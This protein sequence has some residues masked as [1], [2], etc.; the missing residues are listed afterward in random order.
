MAN[1]TVDELTFQDPNALPDVGPKLSCSA[2]GQLSLKVGNLRLDDGREIF[3]N[4]NGQ[5]RCGDNHRRIF[6]NNSPR[7]MEVYQEGDIIFFTG[8]ADTEQMRILG[9]GESK[10]GIGTA[11]PQA[12][13]QVAGG[14]IMPAVGDSS[15]AGIQFPAGATGDEAFIRYFPVVGETAK[16]QIGIGNDLDDSLSLVQAGAE[17]LTITNGRVGI[18]TTTPS[19]A[20]H[21]EPN[22]IQSG[23]IG[24]GLSFGNRQTT[25]FVE[26]PTGGERWIWYASGGVARL[27]SGS[28]KLAVTSTG[29]VGIGTSN[30]Q[31]RLQIL[32][33]AI[34]PAVG[35]S[36]QAGIQ[37]PPDPGGGLGDEAYIRYFVT[38]GE[39]TRLVIGV[40]NDADDAI[41]LFQAGGERLT[42]F[43]G[44]VGIGNLSPTARL[45]VNGKIHAGNSDLYFTKVDHTHTGFGNITGFAAIENASDYNALMILGRSGTPQGRLVRLWDYLDVNGSLNITGSVGIGTALGS[46]NPY[47][48]FEINRGWGDWISLRASQ[49]NGLWHLHNPQGGD[50]FEIGRNE[51]WGMFVIKNAGN[52][53]IGT[54]EPTAKFHVIGNATK[55]V[56][57]TGWTFP[58]D[59]RLKRNIEPLTGTLERLLQLRGV[60]FEWIEP[61]KMG[62]PHALQ[63]GL[64]A[65]EVETVFPEWVSADAQGC[66]HL[67]MTGFEALLIEALRELK[68]EIDFLKWKTG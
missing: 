8:N 7:Q 33:G 46:V 51:T 5:L 67:T 35:N 11:A 20:L 41:G 61:E 14:A 21:V 3:F 55:T 54:V 68:S 57:G 13:L 42:V 6:F 48:N 32:G 12:K 53:G 17:R 10:V 45:D 4:D 34:M 62:D 30:P 59:Q 52:V 50:R 39:T 24:G 27:W 23:G 65:Q 44:N 43:N 22:E 63:R 29:S 25:G 26:S 64:V 36:N 9:N 60:S 15:Q 49:D 31:A 56:G 47:G 16:L 38:A 18:G 2:P 40:G 66:K 19:R 28:D 37:F 58:S 1:L